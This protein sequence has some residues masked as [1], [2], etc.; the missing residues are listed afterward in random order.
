MRILLSVSPDGLLRRF[1]AHGHAGVAVRG[2]NIAC[3]AVTALLR[4]TG[5]LCVARGLALEGGH[6]D[7]GEMELCVAAAAPPQSEWLRGVTDF[8]LRGIRDLQE[9]FP[10]EIAVRME[11]TEV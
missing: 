4:T 1:E 5:R 7:P 6:G 11:T 9:E 8:L 3:A 10:T 2:S